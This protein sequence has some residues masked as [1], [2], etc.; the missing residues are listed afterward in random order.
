M[1][2]ENRDSL[3][4]LMIF[5]YPGG[6]KGVFATAINCMDGRVQSPVTQWLKKKYSI[7]F[8]DVI[9]DAGPNYILAKNLDKAAVESIKKRVE[10]SVMKHGSK[11]IAV[12]G[13]HDCA[14]NPAEKNIQIK[15]N[16]SAM[17]TVQSWK[18]DVEIIGLWVDDNWEV[19]EVF[20]L[21]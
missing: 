8:V 14:G 18:L 17:K 4:S 5:A 19:S 11:L 7:D 21:N 13:H 20:P 2:D 12:V 1:R 15:H 10:M 16:L 6:V 3:A 9:T